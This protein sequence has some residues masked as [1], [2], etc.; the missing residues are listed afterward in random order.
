MPPD[1]KWKT[2][3]KEPK[4][5]LKLFSEIGSS[6]TIQKS[7]SHHPVKNAGFHF[8]EIGSKNQNLDEKF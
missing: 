5:R 8:C 6:T 4:N 1:K 3:S 7:L 2:G